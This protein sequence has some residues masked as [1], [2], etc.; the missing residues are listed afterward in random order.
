[1]W[2]ETAALIMESP[3][4]VVG[5]WNYPLVLK[6]DISAA[7]KGA[8]AH[9]LYLHILSEMGILG[10]SAFVLA[11]GA[12]F[13]ILYRLSFDVS[14]AEFRAFGWC[15][16]FGFV[17]AMAYGLFDVVL[18]NDKA[19]L[20]FAAFVGIICAVYHKAHLHYERSVYSH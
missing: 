20:F 15:A 10:F 13:I 2:K 17:W 12:V 5:P 8:S 3:L 19:L 11:L 18:L 9:N 4:F 7:K 6:E 1:I 16:G 14:L